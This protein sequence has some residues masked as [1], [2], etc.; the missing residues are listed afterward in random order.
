VV[1]GGFTARVDFSGLTPGSVGLYQINTAV[2][3]GVPSGTVDVSVEA[4][5]VMSNVAKMAVQ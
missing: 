5:G 2:P 3:A 1:I 4:N